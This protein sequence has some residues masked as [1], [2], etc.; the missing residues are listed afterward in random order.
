MTA[1]T[2][3]RV[4]MRVLD[5]RLHTWGLP[6]YQSAMA[7]GIDLHACLD[8][9]ATL[10]PQAPA[11]LVPTGLAVSMGEADMVG[12]V[13]A[14]SGL[15]HRDGLVLGQGVGTI[16]ADYQ[17][18]IFVSAWLRT[19]P[20]SAPFTIRPGDRIAQLVFL[21]ILRPDFALVDGFSTATERA[22]GGFGS[23]GIGAGPKAD[24]APVSRGQVRSPR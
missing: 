5:P 8:E 23:T 11:L 2:A 22:G 9:P 17:A 3:R 14:R 24:A 7:A 15:G 6:D 13:L 16:D 4:E 18:E 1:A 19:P 20:G 10:E 12:F 21:P